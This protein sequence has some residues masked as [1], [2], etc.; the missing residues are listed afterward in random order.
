MLT[1][2]ATAALAITLL[3]AS[4]FALTPLEPIKS[5]FEDTKQPA[6]VTVIEKN[7]AWPL[8]QRMSMDPC[9]VTICQEA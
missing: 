2:F 3:G 1:R 8:K 5:S 6:G 7:S 9:T 4:A